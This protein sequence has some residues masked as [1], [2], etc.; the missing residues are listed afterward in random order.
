MGLVRAIT[1]ISLLRFYHSICDNLRENCEKLIWGTLGPRK[2][3][4]C[5]EFE[6]WTSLYS[7]RTSFQTSS[8]RATVSSDY[9]S[10][11]S[12]IA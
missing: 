12:F 5:T 11:L 10:F 3:G 4:F 8:H 6:S 2:G 1:D 9:F 7:L